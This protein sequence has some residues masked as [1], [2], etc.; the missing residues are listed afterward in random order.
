MQTTK[1]QCGIH[2]ITKSLKANL[3]QTFRIQK[4]QISNKCH[5]RL[6]TLPYFKLDHNIQQFSLN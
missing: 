1:D 2:F 4:D 5:A 6:L 3:W